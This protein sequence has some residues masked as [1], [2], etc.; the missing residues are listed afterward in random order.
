MMYEALLWSTQPIDELGATG[1]V[2]RTAIWT[3]SILT[4]LLI[5]GLSITFLRLAKFNHKLNEVLNGSTGELT[6]LAITDSLTNLYN[7]RAVYFRV[8]KEW[9]NY[10]AKEQSNA[11]IIFDLDGFQSN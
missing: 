6:K 5:F 7:R 11:V 10:Y 3:I 9:S 1:P 2:S 4:G 8:K